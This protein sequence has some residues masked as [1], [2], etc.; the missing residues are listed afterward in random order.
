MATTVILEVKAKPGTGN[1]VLAKFKE[2]LPDT[3]GYDGCISLD[4]LQNQEDPD[5]IMLVENWESKAHYDKYLAWRKE[6]GAFDQLASALAGEPSIR[7]FDLT[8]A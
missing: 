8:D 3:R 5:T 1:E 7:Y 6:T 2:V 4:T